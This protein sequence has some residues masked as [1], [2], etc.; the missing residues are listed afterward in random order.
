MSVVR[1]SVFCLGLVV[2]FGG[3]PRYAFAGPPQADPPA[4]A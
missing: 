4:T 1:R 2:V 3:G